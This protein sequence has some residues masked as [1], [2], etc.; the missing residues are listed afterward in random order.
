MSVRVS[1]DYIEE[2]ALWHDFSEE[3]DCVSS[4]DWEWKDCDIAG[5]EEG[6]YRLVCPTCGDTMNRDC[7]EN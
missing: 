1:E 7:E 6:C 3:E 4:E 2:Q 5:H